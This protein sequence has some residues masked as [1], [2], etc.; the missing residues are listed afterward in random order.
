M[1][2]QNSTA[3]R[4]QSHSE[5]ENSFQKTT[6]E[7]PDRT[8]AKE[9][10]HSAREWINGETFP[11]YS[12]DSKDIIRLDLAY[13]FF[14]FFFF[15]FNCIIRDKGIASRKYG[16][17]TLVWPLRWLQ[18]KVWSTYLIPTGKQ[19]RK[20]EDPD[21]VEGRTQRPGILRTGRTVHKH[22]RIQLHSQTQPSLTHAIIFARLYQCF[23][24]LLRFAPP[25]A[26]VLHKLTMNVGCVLTPGRQTD[27]S[28]TI[29]NQNR[30][31]SDGIAARTL[32]NISDSI[33]FLNISNVYFP[34]TAFHVLRE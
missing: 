17:Q 22:T 3:L 14:F 33:F 9:R 23:L 29:P 6:A 8:D 19:G 16:E 15:F 10:P 13:Q 4:V 34:S 30:R 32:N 20:N 31:Q 1:I 18:K 11:I 7:Q 25:L 5:V 26:T 21:S 24:F 12:Q 28:S 2:T 27:I